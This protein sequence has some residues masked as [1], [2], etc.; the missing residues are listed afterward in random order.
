[1]MTKNQCGF[2]LLEILIAITLLSFVMLGV[3]S[4]TENSTVTKER[5]SREDRES[6]QIET[7]MA[8]LQFDFNHIYTPLF[9]DVKMLFDE[10]KE[11]LNQ[12]IQ[13]RYQQNERFDFPD[14]HS[15]PIPR[16]SAPEKDTFEF[17]TLSNRRK[18]QNQKQSRYNWVKYTVES[19]KDPTDSTKETKAFVRYASADNPYANE[20]LDTSRMKPQVLLENIEKL[21]FTFWDKRN[22]KWQ[23][24]LEYIEN[25]E[26]LIRGLKIEIQWKDSE[27]RELTTTRIF[28]ALFPE[29]TP[30]N[31]YT[32]LKQKVEAAENNSS[33]NTNNTN[34]NNNQNNDDD[35]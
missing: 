25:G 4:V 33:N 20:R 16:F 2:T 6:L 13:S 19:V 24:S 32:I 21:V 29:F 11:E 31:P 8:K 18:F 34:S 12:L 1:M 7:A 15:R 9:F 28:R 22:Q 23:D 26:N 14:Y 30:E 17:F 3:I 5:V 35:E 10:D 27:E